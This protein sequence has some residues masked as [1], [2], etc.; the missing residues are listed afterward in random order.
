M[1]LYRKIKFISKLS[2]LLEAI[3]CVSAGIYLFYS[4]YIHIV[5]WFMMSIFVFIIPQ[6]YI[7]FLIDKLYVEEKENISKISDCIKKIDFEISDNFRETDEY[8]QVY[9]SI[10]EVNSK[11]NKNKITSEI[12][13]DIL[14]SAAKNFDFENFLDDALIKIMELM[15]SN[16][17]VFYIVNKTT[18]KL[19]IKSSIGF[20]KSIYSQ[21]DISIGE[22]FI[23]QAAEN[24]KIKIIKDIPDDSIYISKT[25]MGKIKPKNILVVP[26]SDFENNNDVLGVLALASLYEYTDEDIENIN[27]IKKYITYAVLNGIYYNKNQ[28][29]TN[30]LKFQNQLI[31]NLNEDLENKI[32]ERTVFLNNIINSIKDVAIVSV[33][34]S[35]RITLFSKGA[36]KLLMI[37]SEEAIGQNIEIVSYGSEEVREKVLSSIEDAIKNGTSLHICDVKRK[38]GTYYSAHI[39]LFALY[40]EVGENNGVTIVVKDTSFIKKIVNSAEIDKKMAE[41]LIDESTRAIMIVNEEYEILKIN[42]NSEYILDVKAE[43]AINKKVW[44]FF[45]DSNEVKNFIIQ[46]MTGDKQREIST[47]LLNSD[48]KV[49][50]KTRL[51]VDKGSN[52]KKLMIFLH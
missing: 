49:M 17:I 38:D 3:V 50:L 36:E 7:T 1:Y 41:T 9:E 15:N 51:L 34:K 47:K 25:F 18:N 39:E 45:D 24:N 31:Q 42:K 20:G 35:N 48:I 11:I 8:E 33:D 46:I 12:I 37:N 28:R 40:N 23:G 4:N 32:K 10:S 52:L 5:T 26:V 44:E 19:E 2:L 43:N 13:S 6:V 30:E 29:L 22:G 27:K 14:V 16:W 21:F